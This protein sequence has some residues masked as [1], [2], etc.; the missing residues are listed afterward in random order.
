LNAR[1]HAGL[2]ALAAIKIPSL[3]KRQSALTGY[4]SDAEN[5]TTHM[6]AKVM[7]FWRNKKA[8]IEGQLDVFLEAE[9][10]DDQ[11]SPTGREKRQRYFATAKTAWETALPVVLV[12]LNKAIVAPYALGKCYQICGEVLHN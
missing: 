11:L 12:N 8:E 10:S 9:Q 2:K 6:S 5:G 7:A 1:D 3:T 4:I